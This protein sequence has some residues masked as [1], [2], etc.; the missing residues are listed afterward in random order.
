MSV[1]GKLQNALMAGADMA[2]ALR[3]RSSPSENLLRR[4]RLI[5]HRGEHNGRDVQENTIPA[6]DAAL[7]A[8]VWGLELDVRW[9]RDLN[10]VVLHDADLRRVFGRNHRVAELTLNE[11]QSVCPQVPT[12]AQLI[13]RYA[14]RA[15]LMVEI[16]EEPYPE[17]QR[18]NEI[19]ADLFKPLT[20][21]EDY[22]LL[23]LTPRMFEVVTF[24][25]RSACFPIAQTRV[26]AISRLA[27][28]GGFGGLL[29]HYTLVNDSLVRQHH[30]SRRKIGTGYIG[31]RNCL[32]REV[33]RGVDFIF[34]NCAARMQRMVDQ[35][36][37]LAADQ[38]VKP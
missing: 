25:P 9:T 24:A 1:R 21:G 4:C 29:G 10:P 36:L 18:Q 38:A 27:S 22:H 30:Q 32:F 15:H 13:D 5:S 19:L 11:L 37:S 12:L 16:K 17:P 26:A 14:G 34:S 35:L 6:F 31:S 33:R 7:S 2:Y 23:S 3:P 20:T 28:D 8:G